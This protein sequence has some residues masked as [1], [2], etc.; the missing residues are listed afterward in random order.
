MPTLT[1]MTRTISLRLSEPEFETLK[2]L[3]AKHGAR[4]ISDFARTAMQSFIS[5]SAQ[6]SFALE[7]KVQEIDG[8][9]GVLDSEV[10]RLSAL[11]RS[12]LA[13]RQEKRYE[14]D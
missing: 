12:E 5:R 4:S 14:T 9:L 13:Q 3:Y 10:A 7:L 8:K 6:G 2:A 1:R 11:I